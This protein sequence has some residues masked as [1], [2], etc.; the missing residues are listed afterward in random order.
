MITVGILVSYLVALLILKVAPGSAGGLDWRLI[1]GIGAIPALVAVALRA[2]MPESPRW[3]MLHGRYADTAKAF[4]LLGMDVSEEQAKQ[5]ADELA[6]V[7]QARRRTTAWTAHREPAGRLARVGRCPR[8]GGDGGVRHRRQ[9]QRSRRQG[10]GLRRPAAERERPTRFAAWFGQQ[11]G[12]RAPSRWN[13]SLDAVRSAAAYW[14]RQGWIAADPSR[15]LERRKPRPDRARALFR[16]DV[17]QLL[18]RE[19]VGLRERTLWRMLYE[20]AARSAEVLA[21]N[22]EDLDL[23]NRRAKVRRKGG[24]IDVIVWQTGTARLLPRL[25]KSRKSGP[26]FVTERKARVQLPTADLDPSGRARLSYQQAAA[27]FSEASGGATLHQLRHSA[28]T[29]DAEDGTGTPMLMARSGHTSVRSLGCQR[30]NTLPSSLRV[31]IADV[32][33]TWATPFI[34]GSGRRALDGSPSCSFCGAPSCPFSSFSFVLPLCVAPETQPGSLARNGRLPSACRAA[35]RPSVTPPTRCLSGCRHPVLLTKHGHGLA[36]AGLIHGT[37]RPEPRNSRR[38]REVG[39]GRGEK[40]SATLNLRLKPGD[41]PLYHPAST[42]QRRRA[43]RTL[44]STVC[45]SARTLHDLAIAR[46]PRWGAIRRR[47]ARS[48]GESGRSLAQVDGTSRPL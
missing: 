6:Q 25:L 21:L 3:L 40:P 13:V 34:V 19:G 11:W 46:E 30:Y 20:T 4:G 2:R 16:A 9:R 32:S 28:L 26:V 44:C 37:A 33:P 24:A 43:P 29:H 1:L 22:V 12:E 27:L 8:P 47:A 35:S 17:E 18:T 5:A 23:A 7:E 42:L 38:V 39:R 10:R 48:L 45:S 36:A 31:T 41:N 15:M 14:Q